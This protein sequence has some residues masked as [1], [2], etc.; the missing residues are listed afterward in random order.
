MRMSVV[1]N[2]VSI[3]LLAA[4]VPAGAQ[5]KAAAGRD[6]ARELCRRDCRP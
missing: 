2:I 3:A 5:A 4:A 1:R 6:D